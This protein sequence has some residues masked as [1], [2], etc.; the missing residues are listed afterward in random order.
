MKQKIIILILGII[1]SMTLYAQSSVAVYITS[2]KDVSQETKKVLGSELV[3]AITSTKDYVAVE[4]TADFLAQVKQEQ[5][6]YE[7]DDAALMD[8]GRKFGAS[9]VCVADITKFS[10]EYYIVARLLDIKTAKVWKTSRQYSTLKSL[11]ELIVVSQKLAKDLFVT[12]IPKEYSSYVFSDN[13][14]NHSC[15]VKIENRDDYTMV[16]LN[17]L[18]TD[19]RQ[20]IGINR[21]SYIE[22]M[23]THQKYYLKDASNINVIDDINKNGKLI[24]AGL[25]E[26]Y[27]FFERIAEDTHNIMIIEPN[28]R[29]YNDI[30]LK[31]Y[32]DENVFVFY[33][34]WGPKIAIESAIDRN[35]S[36]NYDEDIRQNS[37][38]DKRKEERRKSEE[39]FVDDFGNYLSVAFGNGISYGGGNIFGIALTKRIG[40]VFGI[41]PLISIGFTAIDLTHTAPKLTYSVGINFFINRGLYLSSLYGV[42]DYKTHY[43]QITMPNGIIVNQ[44]SSAEILNYKGLSFLVGWKLYFENYWYLDFAAGC[45]MHSDETG[46]SI[47]FDVISSAWNIGFGLILH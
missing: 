39:K 46:K 33:Y 2:S 1:M 13:V 40:G 31:P 21:G 38:K 15:I 17:Y 36:N 35:P 28:G 44:D 42:N 7:I 34:E 27:L 45:K 16:T 23:T 37:Q 32:G 20:E 4:R 6:N 14:D 30:I 3:S 47:G 41:E 25:W 10:D 22:D 9:N 43:E 5:G 11:Q 8:L 29:K 24:G 26:Y 18:S 12:E 19:Q